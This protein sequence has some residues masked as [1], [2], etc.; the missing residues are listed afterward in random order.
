MTPRFFYYFFAL[1]IGLTTGCKSLDT[2]LSIKTEA[3]PEAFPEADTDTNSIA[4][5]NWR[6]YFKDELLLQLIDEGLANNLDLQM[7]LQRIE[8][9]R[10]SAKFARQAMLPTAGAVAGG[11]VRRFGR[12]TMDGA[13]NIST[14]MTPGRIVPVNLPDILL[15]FQAAWEVDLWGKL[16]NQKKAA[17]AQL[18]AS[19]EG[20]NLITSNLVADIAGYYYELLALDNELN[21]I[22]QTIVKQQEAL[23][24][25]KLQ[26]EAGRANEL[27]VQQFTAQLLA[28]QAMEFETRQNV[29]LAENNINVLLGRFP[30]AIPRN[31]AELLTPVPE[32]LIAGIPSQLLINRPD[33]R[34]AEFSLQ[35]TKFDLQAARAAFFPSF[36]IT[37]SLGYNAFSPQ[38]LFTTPAS[39][40]FTALGNLA[41][42]LINRNELNMR[43][44]TAKASQ[45]EAMYEYQYTIITAFSEVV[46]EM[47]QL[48]NLRQNLALKSRQAEILDQAVFT[49]RELYRSARAEYLEV[50]IAQQ[51]A[52]MADLELI[53]LLRRQKASAVQLY[54]VLGGGWR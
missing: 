44:A 49:S 41:A 15:G 32:N 17:A 25:I 43:F 6:E 27:A 50:L 52:L 40:A 35:A 46:T 19:V 10:A 13:G 7:A 28:T 34:R 23:E 1:L 45:L 30:R 24:V 53:S 21:I 39:L 47:N 26:K 22:R 2:N 12:Y 37:G 8:M 36:N 9:S 38:F 4:A 5:M 42:P 20:R 54:K 31:A 16:K 18:L 14:E 48:Q 3:L 51:N 29:V 11:G 33:I